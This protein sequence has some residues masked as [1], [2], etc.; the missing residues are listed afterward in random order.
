MKFDFYG[1]I[2]PKS[3]LI[4][5]YQIQF[6]A[7]MHGKL[8]AH[9]HLPGCSLILF[10]SLSSSLQFR[11]L[12]FFVSFAVVQSTY[13]LLSWSFRVIQLLFF[14]PRRFCFPQLQKYN[15][16]FK[17]NFPLKGL[18]TVTTKYTVVVQRLQVL[19]A[20]YSLMLHH[21]SNTFFLYLDHGSEE[22]GVCLFK[23]S[24]VHDINL[25]QFFCNP[26][27][28]EIYNYRLLCINSALLL[29]RSAIKLH[30]N[31]HDFFT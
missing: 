19:F 20:Y 7:N 12:R 10:P 15:I 2:G 23:S 11:P 18:V 22:N 9:I 21:L 13:L 29:P 5:L 6:L 28:I 8:R 31:V 17:K 25:V 14:I 3:N 16:N 4:S 27:L 26:Y 24:V 30:Q 1:Y